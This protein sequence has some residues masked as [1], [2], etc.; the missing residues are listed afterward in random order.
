[1]SGENRVNITVRLFG[2]MRDFAGTSTVNISLDPR[3]VVSELL[4][5]LYR[6]YPALQK[7]L[8]PGL[9]KGYINLV[10]NGRNV[11]FLN[12]LDTLLSDGDRV[13]FLPPI[14]GG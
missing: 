13:A 6:R 1:M 11:R 7:R 12:G 2:G 9:T 10:V 8:K 5:E 3:A 14:G 4:A